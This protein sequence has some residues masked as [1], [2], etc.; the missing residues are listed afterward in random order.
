MNNFSDVNAELVAEA[1]NE[2]DSGNI[3]AAKSILNDIRENEIK[4]SHHGKRADA[5]VKSM[6]Q[7]SI[8]GKGVKEPT[9]K[10]TGHGT[11]LGL[12]LSY[13]IIKAH[14]GG[15]KVA[16][17]EG[18]F[19]IHCFATSLICLSASPTRLQNLI[20]DKFCILTYAQNN[21][22]FSFPQPGEPDK[23]KSFN[24]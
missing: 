10:P 12:L 16:S 15:I 22:G 18:K 20:D 21:R 5:I 6:L 8:T 11:G 19:R 9:N 4:I 3:A 2:I 1:G 7:H 17:G 13:D 14:G 23:I 24:F